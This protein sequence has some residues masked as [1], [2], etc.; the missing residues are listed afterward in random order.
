MKPAKV[1]KVRSFLKKQ[2]DELIAVKKKHI[3]NAVIQSKPHQAHLAIKLDD[4]STNG[5]LNPHKAPF[6]KTWAAVTASSLASVVRGAISDASDD[7]A[8]LA[9]DH[10]QSLS[11][12]AADV[13]DSDEPIDVDESAAEY[14]DDDRLDELETKYI[15]NTKFGAYATLMKVATAVLAGSTLSDLADSIG[16]DS[17]DPDDIASGLFSSIDSRTETY[18]RTETGNAYGAAM[19][20]AAADNDIQKRWATIDPGCEEVCHP[21]DGQVVDMDDL[22]ELGN[23]EAIDYPPAHPNC[24]CTW[25]P[26]KEDWGNTQS[27][28]DIEAQE[29][30]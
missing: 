24:D 4:W 22:F 12:F 7:A 1:K 30:A 14:D 13:F 25:I 28:D 6:A 23:D 10:L 2:H 11:E 15:G 16:V 3:R 21:T 17:D 19:D 20:D 26:W 8:A 29:A 9:V 5:K 18:V 27:T